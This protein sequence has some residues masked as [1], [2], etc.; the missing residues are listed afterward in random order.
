MMM[1]PYPFGLSR[2]FLAL[3]LLAGVILVLEIRVRGLIMLLFLGKHV[4]VIKTP[5]LKDE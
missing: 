1:V 3:L 4:F 5:I 2:S